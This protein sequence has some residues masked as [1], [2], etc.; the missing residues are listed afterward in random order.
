M[1]NNSHKKRELSLEDD[2]NMA[3][4]PPKKKNN[5]SPVLHR[6]NTDAYKRLKKAKEEEKHWIEYGHLPRP[7]TKQKI[8]GNSQVWK[9]LMLATDLRMD[10][11]GYTSRSSKLLKLPE[12]QSLEEAISM[13]FVVL[14]SSNR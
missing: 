10:L 4:Q 7:S 11:G 14:K 1:Y 6:K 13:G 3:E 5:D 2:D 9:S 12:I 8:Y